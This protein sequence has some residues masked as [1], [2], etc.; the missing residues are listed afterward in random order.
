MVDIVTNTKNMTREEWL[1]W[2]KEGI[3]GSDVSI[4]CGI[5]KYKSAL[6]LWMEKRG[7]KESEEAGESAYWGSTL[8]PI[9]RE[10]FTKRTNLEVDTISL[11]LKH[12]EFDFMLAN[13]DGIVNDNE[14]KKCIF[15]A[16]TASAYKLDQWKDDEIPEEYML[17]IQ[18]YM[19]VLNYERTY[20]AV[21]IGGN[22][23]KYKV[24]YRDEELIDMIIEIEKNFWNC[25]LND[26]PPNIDGSESCTNLLNNLY[27]KAKKNCSIILPSEAEE[28]INEYNINKE[29][30]KFYSD[31]KDEC[32]NKI[33]AM[34]EDNEAGAINNSIV[35]WKNTSTERLDSK[36]L[37]E[38][39]SEIYEKYIKKTTTRRFLI[40]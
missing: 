25:V 12:P 32:I 24:V 30:E 3:G 11:M 2:R 29:K 18:H 39:Q 9:I 13:V 26:I 38:E 19:A 1:Q 35:T 37:K 20:I 16:K 4:I 10:E 14:G 5:N 27:P 31:K 6:E 7:Y 8:E 36:K 40:K 34:M 17:Q 28:I 15:E 33:K 23:F 21:L 22:T